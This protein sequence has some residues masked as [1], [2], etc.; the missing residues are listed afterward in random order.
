ML[1]NRNTHKRD[2]KITFIEETHQ[3]WFGKKCFTSVTTLINSLF[4]EFDQTKM[5]HRILESPTKKEIYKNKSF[6]EIEEMWNKNKNESIQAGLALHKDIED[7]YD[8]KSIENDSV[9]YQ[10]FLKF[11]DDH[12]NQWIPYRSEWRIYDEDYELAGTVDMC[13]VRN[14]YLEIVDWKRCRKISN[15]NHSGKFSIETYLS[16]LADTNYNHYALQL[17]FYKYIIERK[18]NKIVKSMYI[19]CLHPENRNNNYIMMKVPEMKKEVK[20]ILKHLKNK[21]SK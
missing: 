8:E 10:Y 2:N 20:L 1:A 5:I 16:H 3:Y 9:E 14:G 4:E 7:Y 19:V 21:I 11:L 18:Y 17:N 6:H 13:Y 15:D 12:K